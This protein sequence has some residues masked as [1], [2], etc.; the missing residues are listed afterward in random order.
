VFSGWR[1][2]NYLPFSC[3]L[4]GVLGWRFDGM[5]MREAEGLLMYYSIYRGMLTQ[6]FVYAVWGLCVFFARSGTG[7]FTFAFL[8]L[9][10]CG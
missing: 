3:L 9:F 6:P 1:E 4:P 2:G 7:S 8:G 5:L 10:P